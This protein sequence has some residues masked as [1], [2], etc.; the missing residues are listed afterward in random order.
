MLFVLFYVATLLALVWIAAPLGHWGNLLSAGVATAATVAIWER[1]R[2]RLGLFVEPRVAARELL[3]G[4][5]W[6]AVLVGACALLVAATT[7]LRHVRGEGFPW[8]ELM[9]VF[10]PAAVHEEL[11][12]RGYPFQKLHQWNRGVAL[13]LFAVVFA[14]LHSG[15]AGVTHLGL[16]NIFFGGILL[17]LAWER[18]QRLWLP[19]GVHLAWN[20]MTGPILGHEVSGYESSRTLLIEVGGGPPWLTGGDFGIEASVWMTGVEVAAIWFLARASRRRVGA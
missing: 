18:Y 20:L 7:D 2:W 16:V 10:L 6:G 19:I 3:A 11:L 8:L 14:A 9:V 15:N 4:C 5:A 17:G 1:G 13:V 12:F